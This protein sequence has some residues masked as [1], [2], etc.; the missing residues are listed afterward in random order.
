MALP[1]V[2]IP[3]ADRALSRVAGAPLIE[4]NQVRLLLD[5][6]ENYPAWLEAVRAAR[7]HIHFETFI[8]HEDEVG[9]EFADLFIEK[10]RQGVRVRLIYDWLGCAGNASW[11]WWK[12]LR[13][14]GVETRCYNPPRL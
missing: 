9:K 4:G 3:L 6:R 7:H 1:T 14:A 13:A 12:R 10:A 11:S 8:F 5:A 2:G